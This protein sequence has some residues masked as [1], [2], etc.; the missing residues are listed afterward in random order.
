MGDTSLTRSSSHVESAVGVMSDDELQE[1]I[2]L[3]CFSLHSRGE[4]DLLL[5]D[6]QT[7]DL[8][9]QEISAKVPDLPDPALIFYHKLNGAR[10]RKKEL[11]LPSHWSSL[12]TR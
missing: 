1:T 6:R 8:S 4:N 5:P 7:R 11:I 10:I 2:S 12:K 9:I 3:M